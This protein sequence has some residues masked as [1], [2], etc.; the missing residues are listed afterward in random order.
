M[1][2][3]A[4][5]WARPRAWYFACSRL[6]A[7]EAGFDDALIYDELNLA[8]GER[9]IPGGHIPFEACLEPFLEWAKSSNKIK[10]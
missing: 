10:Y 9:S 1:C 8:P 3:G 2:L 4:I 6:A 7:A 5:F